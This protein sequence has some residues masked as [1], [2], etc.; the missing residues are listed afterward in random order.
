MDAATLPTLT[1][2]QE[3]IL[4]CIVRAY[5]AKAEPVGSKYIAESFDLGVS[6]ATIRNEMAV[7]EELGYIVQPHTSA[8]RVPSES[9][10]RY[11]VTYLL[12][13]IELS[14]ADQQRIS[15][16]MTAVPMATEQW[17]RQAATALSRITQAASL[18]TSPS[19]QTGRFKH[20]E[21]ISVQGRL[22]LMVL[23]LQGGGVHQRMLNLAE[24]VPQATLSEVSIRVNTLC[25]DLSARDILLKAIG[26]PLLEREILELAA[27][28]ME[29]ASNGSIQTV[30]R[31]GLSDML[32]SFPASEGAQ[33]A[34]RVFEE[35]QF[36]NVIIDEFLGP[37]TDGV[38]VVIAGDGRRDELNHLSMV[39]SRYGHPGQLSGA[40]GLIGP[41]HINY[42]RAIS[43]VRYVS[44]T[45]TNM[46]VSLYGNG[47]GDNRIEG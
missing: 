35:R 40:I 22:A 18:V 34:V 38:Q 39:L 7:L 21:L 24:S 37:L 17:M 19:S 36:L 11:F 5:S 46:L 10:Y 30:Y 32:Q 1:R 12:N 29:R 44:T 15:E 6:P 23:I 42:G 27:E 4:A 25:F 28:V 20:V 45:M 14:P 33:Q 2:R 31:D 41:T 3:Q 8:G 16:R 43:A 47:D 9:G 13:A 26:L